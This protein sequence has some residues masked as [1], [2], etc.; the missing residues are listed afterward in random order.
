MFARALDRRQREAMERRN[1][2]LRRRRGAKGSWQVQQQPTPG[3]VAAGLQSPHNAPHSA[4]AGCR[5]FFKIL[6]SARHAR[7]TSK[8]KVPGSNPG[9][10]ANEINRL[11]T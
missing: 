3:T 6:Q 2:G 1:E 8:L 10:V 4:D 9:G 7:R 5:K 11:Q